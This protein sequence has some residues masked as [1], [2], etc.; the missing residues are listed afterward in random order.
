MKFKEIMKDVILKENKE[1]YEM[2]SLHNIV[3]GDSITFNVEDNKVSIYISLSS[4]GKG[5][6]INVKN[7]NLVDLIQNRWKE[8]ENHLNLMKKENDLVKLIIDELKDLDKKINT[9]V[10]KYIENLR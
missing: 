8:K 9:M 3:E 6:T 5:G 7:D 10:T 4:G 1:S 2:K